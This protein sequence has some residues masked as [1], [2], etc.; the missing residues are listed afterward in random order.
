ME[1]LEHLYIAD[2]NVKWFC[3]HGEWFGHSSKNKKLSYQPAF[4]R[5][6]IQPK[7]LKTGTQI[8][9]HTYL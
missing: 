3:F 7:E 6:A 8:Y 4:L 2:R 9:V 5:I 1:I